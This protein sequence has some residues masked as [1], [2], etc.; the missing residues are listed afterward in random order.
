MHE[1]WGRWQRGLSRVNI[2]TRAL[3]TDGAVGCAPVEQAAEVV[4]G[5]SP[6]GQ[7]AATTLTAL[8]AVAV[9]PWESVTENVTL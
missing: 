6:G 9:A 7:R 3:A 8:T 4:Q 2:G 1:Q 5:V